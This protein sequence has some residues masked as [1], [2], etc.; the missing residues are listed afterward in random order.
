MNHKDIALLNFEE[1]NHFGILKKVI[2][3][4]V[5]MKSL[6]TQVAYAELHSE[7]V[8]IEH[9]HD[10][11][12]EVFFV[13]EGSC[14]FEL[15]GVLHILKKESVIKIPPR[16]FHRIKALSDSKLFYFSVAL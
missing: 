12:E 15:D 9:S 13:L 16:T 8:V 5:E 7:D 2:F 10:S 4:G 3:T 1:S 6:V 14:E 11:M